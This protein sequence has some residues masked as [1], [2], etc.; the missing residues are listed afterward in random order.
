MTRKDGPPEPTPYPASKARGGD[1]VLRTRKE[2]AIFI[3][4]LAGA[5]VLAVIWAVAATYS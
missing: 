2:R 4:G 3:A 5:L 1:I